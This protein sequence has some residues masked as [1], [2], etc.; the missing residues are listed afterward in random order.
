MK[1]EIIKL[2][3]F[4]ALLAAIISGGTI[5]AG[6][7]ASAYI[8]KSQ[9]FELDPLLLAIILL[10]VGIIVILGIV[11]A[12]IKNR[13]SKSK[14]SREN[15]LPGVWEGTTEQ[16][17]GDGR[18]VM[19]YPFQIDISRERDA[20]SGLLVI[21]YEDDIDNLKVELYCRGKFESDNYFR[22]EY[23]TTNDYAVHFGYAILRL[24]GDAK[25][26]EGYFLGVGVESRDIV[27][28][29]IKVKKLRGKRSEIKSLPTLKHRFFT[30]VPKMTLF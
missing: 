29:K 14:N 18:G 26:L 22:L 19:E 23:F 4:E 13:S 17:M 21:K 5:A 3:R 20:F 7:I 15:T 2:L 16:D 10:V 24:S 1:G 25:T 12:V 28:G 8:N 9:G 11:V 6:S 27:I 30:A